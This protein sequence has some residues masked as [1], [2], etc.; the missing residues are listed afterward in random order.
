MAQFKY[1][2]RDR[3]GKK[4]S[5]VIQADTKQAVRI[6]LRERGLRALDVEQ[7]KETIWNTDIYI[8]TPVKL[9]DFVIYLRQFSTLIKAGV[10][11]VDS[12]KI[13]V[14]QTESKALKKAL[15][16]VE[17]DL[18]EGNSLSS[19][20]ANHPKIFSQLFI[21]MVHAGEVSGSLEET[22]EE[23]AD[24]FEKQQKTRQ[25]VKSALTYPVVIGVL[26]LGV[27]AF[28]LLSIVPTFVGMFDQFG[29]ELPAVTKAVMAASEWMISYWWF[30]VLLIITMTVTLYLMRQKPSTK[31]YLDYALL[32]LPIFGQ[33]IRK[34]LLA[35]LTRTL[36]SLLNNSVSILQAIVLTE[37][38]AGNEVMTRVLRES[39]TTLEQGRSMSE[40][41]R[42]HWAFPPLVTQMIAVGEQTGSL[43]E[44]LGK[45]ADF[46][47]SEVDTATDQLKSLIEPLLIVFLAF[48]VGVIVL[49]I[50]VPMFEI[51][52]NVN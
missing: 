16:R 15:N 11:I 5:G 44:M 8:G 24:Y 17:L 4:K 14:D 43:D 39:R 25:K 26:A 34:S 21:N 29:G 47:E 2:A 41:M 13:L 18:R 40:P 22:L 38:V 27:T 33:L 37:K 46:Y 23:M 31:F 42:M 32:K 19:A 48:I 9:D 1:V 45:I 28:L 36:S 7:K 35:R 12:T 10:T 6:Q 30:V 51:F 50:M 52:N 20:Y 49:S 3:T